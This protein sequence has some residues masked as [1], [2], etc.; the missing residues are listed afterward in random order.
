MQQKD[1]M[2]QFPIP[3]SPFPCIEIASLHKSYRRPSV[4]NAARFGSLQNCS[5]PIVNYLIPG[6][7]SYLK[8]ATK[9]EPR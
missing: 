9:N 8:T 6:N 1:F 4:R 3:Y 2:R 5:V 7:Q